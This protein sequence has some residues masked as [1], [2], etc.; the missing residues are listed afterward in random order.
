M[1]A[2]AVVLAEVPPERV[3]N[4]MTADELLQWRREHRR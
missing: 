3:L 1:G 4:F 2:A